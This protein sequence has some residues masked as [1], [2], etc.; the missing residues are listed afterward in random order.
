MTAYSIPPIPTPYAG[1]VFH[2]QTEARWAVFFDVLGVPWTPQPKLRL[3]EI[4]RGTK[5]RKTLPF[6]AV[7]YIPDF[8]LPDISTWVEVKGTEDQLDQARHLTFRT[9]WHT[10]EPMLILGDM[11]RFH[12]AGPPDAGT[13]WAWLEISPHR[14]TAADQGGPIGPRTR[15]LRATEKH[16]AQGRRVTFHRYPTDQ[17]LTTAERSAVSFHHLGWAETAQVPV[18][19]GDTGEARRAYRAAQESFWPQRPLPAEVEPGRMLV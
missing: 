14:W 3:P 13:D 16:G 11:L 19:T 9:A 17:Q 5:P 4:Y 2:S 8:Y 15:L 12:P 6:D 10:G 1:L 7:D 18:A